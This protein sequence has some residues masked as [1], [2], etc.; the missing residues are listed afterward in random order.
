MIKVL[1]FVLLIAVL[2][3]L[4][5][6]SVFNLYDIMLSVESA[7]VQ[8]GV[9]MLF[10]FSTLITLRYLALMFFSIIKT[11]QRTTQVDRQKRADLKVSIIVPA[12]NE[13]V[14]IE[15]SILSIMDQTYPNIEIVVVDDGSKDYTYAK[16]KALEFDDGISSL[17]VLTKPNGGKAKALN[18]GIEHSRGDLIMVVDAD[19]KLSSDAVELMV[20]YFHDAKIAAVAGSVYVSNRDNTLTR[21][22]ALEYIQGLN[23]VRNGQAFFKLVNIIPGPIGMFRKSAIAQVGGYDSDT[24]AED[25]DLTMKLITQGYKIDFEPEAFA[26]TEAPDELLDL[27]KQ[28]YRWTRGILQSISK[29]KRKLVQVRKYPSI[30]FVLWYM[31]FESIFWPIMDIFG[32]LFFLYISYASGASSF[33]FYWWLLFT[34]LDVAGALYCIL[35]T[36]EK[37]SLALYAVLYRLYFISI[38]NLAK[39]FA[40]IEEWCNIKME[41]GKLD[42]KGGI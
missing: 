34:M 14:V 21:L 17:V 16:A 41:W 8:A 19:S 22:Q 31:L 38:I 12:Y 40:T 18:F 13:E 11:I 9:V 39:I 33:V 25:A 27:I 24:F 1:V 6:V 15:K 20:G 36:G 32:L 7:F 3:I 2:A 26:Y 29:H 5:M 35:T 37:L 10:I 4:S 28:R 23:M 42:R 30:A